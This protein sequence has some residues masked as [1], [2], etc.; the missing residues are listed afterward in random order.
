MLRQRCVI[1]TVG[2]VISWAVLARPADEVKPESEFRQAV[3]PEGAEFLKRLRKGT[4]FGAVDFDLDALRAG[5]GARNEP[6]I[7]GVQL[8]RSMIDDIPV[9]W[10]VAPGADS[11]LRLLYLH[12]GGWVSG[13]GGN[14]LPLAA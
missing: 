13:S 2:A 3:S 7:E 12:G 8:I 1:A 4:P 14:Y 11:G 10:V 6:H 5:M 9:E